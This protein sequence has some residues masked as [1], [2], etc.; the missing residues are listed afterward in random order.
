[1]KRLFFNLLIISFLT[2]I[3]SNCVKEKKIEIPP[4]KDSE[5]CEVKGKKVVNNIGYVKKITDET[6]GIILD[7]TLC[8]EIY[9]YV[10]QGLPDSLKSLHFW[11]VIRVDGE[12]NGKSKTPPA[13]DYIQLDKVRLDPD[14]NPKQLIHNEMGQ[15]P[16]S[17]HTKEAYLISSEKEY[18]DFKTETGF[19][20]QKSIDFDKFALMGY[21]ICYPGC[22]EPIRKIIAENSQENKINVNIIITTSASC[23]LSICVE[24]WYLVPKFNPNTIFSFKLEK[25]IRNF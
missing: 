15:M 23:R 3:F 10:C 19:F 9:Y 1:M 7:D 18:E 25:N 17:K 11:D 2:T 8:N 12:I 4:V 6:W 14:F 20:S 21:C 13:F 5:P 22:C 24:A 16:N